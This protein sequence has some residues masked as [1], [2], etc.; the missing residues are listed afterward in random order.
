MIKKPCNSRFVLPAREIVVG[1]FPAPSK[2]PTGK[3]STKANF[4]F[5]SFYRFFS[6]QFTY[7]YLT[8]KNGGLLHLYINDGCVN[9]EVIWPLKLSGVKKMYLYNTV[10]QMT[11]FLS[12]LHGMLDIILYCRAQN[13]IGWLAHVDPC[14]KVGIVDTIGKFD[15]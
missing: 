2:K 11:M 10:Q 6:P 9:Y 1:F 4:I 5:Y 12:H 8:I 14:Y 7:I 13:M 15:E 3:K